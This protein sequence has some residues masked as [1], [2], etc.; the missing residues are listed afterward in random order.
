MASI[1]K[2]TVLINIDG[3]EYSVQY[4]ISNL[5]DGWFDLNVWYKGN[6]I[7]ERVPQYCANLVEDVISPHGGMLLE[8]LL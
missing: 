3:N 2:G 1:E 8:K 5:I 7:K 4:E 6:S